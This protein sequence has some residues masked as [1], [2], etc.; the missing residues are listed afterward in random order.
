MSNKLQWII[1]LSAAGIV[2]LS[3]AAVTFANPFYTGQK[4]RSA[5]ATTT[6]SFLTPGAATT[7][8][9]LYDSYE[10]NGTNEPNA[11]NITLP[12]SVAVVVQGNA[13]STTSV[14]NLACEF[15]DDNVDWYQSEII[16]ATSTGATNISV[17]VSFTFT[18]ASTTVGGVQNSATRYQKLFECPVPLRYVRVVETNTGAGMSVWTAIIPKKQRN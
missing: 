6:V 2:L 14:L 1:P 4:A 8:S 5:T 13:S 10:Q 15:S 17:P 18:F 12:N 3:F 9:P 16:A 7:T 11:G